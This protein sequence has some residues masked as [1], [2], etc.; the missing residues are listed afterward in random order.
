M[1]KAGGGEQETGE[2]GEA[3]AVTGGVQGREGGRGEE[4]GDGGD[5]VSGSGQ[6]KEAWLGGGDE[7]AASSPSLSRRGSDCTACSRQPSRI[8]SQSSG[9]SILSSGDSSVVSASVEE[10][11][12]TGEIFLLCGSCLVWG[13][14]P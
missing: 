11:T 3:G 5:G 13:R 14:S 12:L 2:V 1:D 6:G 10:A 4:S 7:K 8:A 9:S